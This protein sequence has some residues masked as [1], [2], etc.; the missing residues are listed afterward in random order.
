MNRVQGEGSAGS[1]F[2]YQYATSQ[3][4]LTALQPMGE[5]LVSSLGLFRVHMRTLAGKVL[6]NLSVP[7]TRDSVQDT[8]NTGEERK[9]CVTA[10][11]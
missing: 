4:D 5:D 8:S 3:T 9:T 6:F 10:S 7:P 2:T 11:A 1:G